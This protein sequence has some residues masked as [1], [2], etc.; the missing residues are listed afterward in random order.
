MPEGVT[1]SL[2]IGGDGL[3]RGYLH[4]PDLTAEKFI[5]DPFGGDDQARLYKT[6]DLARYQADGK[7]EFLGREDFQVKVRGFRIELGEIESCLNEHPAIRQSVVI[8]RN[9]SSRINDKHLVAYCTYCDGVPD[10]RELRNF[11]KRTLP[12]YMVPA[13]FVPLD[14][15]PLNSAGKID[16]RSLPAPENS[17]PNLHVSKV[18]PRNDT[19]E[20]LA[21]IWAKVLRLEGVGIHDNFFD[22]GGASMQSLEITSLAAEVG[23]EMV[24]ASLFKHPTIAELAAAVSSSAVDPR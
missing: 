18:A 14:E 8:A 17:Q 3:A 16:R 20:K 2:Y 9:A 4:R 21:A 15:F 6:G 13:V 19:E 11:L 7:I 24:P 23:I 12:D 10:N 22:L 5:R 1:G